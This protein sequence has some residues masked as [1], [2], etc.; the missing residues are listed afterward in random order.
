MAGT[1]TEIKKLVY[2]N[3]EM[4]PDAILADLT[5]RDIKTTKQS[6]AAYRSDFLNSVAL[7]KELGAFDGASGDTVS[8][9]EAPKKKAKKQKNPSRATRWADACTRANDALSD[10]VE[11]Q[12]EYSDW[13]DGLPENL[14]SSPVGEKLEAVCDLDLEGAQ[15]TI[16]EAEGCELP[17]GFGRD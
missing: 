14:A 12:G 7:L 8:V 13:K 2:A 5:A 4:T 9:V 1:A 15:S 16:E 3:P 11:L 10:L 17:L 6:I